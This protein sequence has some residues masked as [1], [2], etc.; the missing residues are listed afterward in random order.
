MT[1]L[2]CGKRKS[3][4]SP[5]NAAEDVLNAEFKDQRTGKIDLKPSA[6]DV[7]DVHSVIVQT[8]AEHYA[9]CGLDPRRL[10]AQAHVV[11]SAVYD[12]NITPDREGISF[13][14]IALAHRE[15]GFEDG[16]QLLQFIQRVLDDVSSLTR[17]TSKEEFERYVEDR[18]REGDTEWKA[19]AA[20]DDK[21]NRYLPP[22][23]RKSN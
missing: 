14:H 23:S 1:L 8:Y 9:Q 11:V 5:G 20:E 16:G 13:R 19:A 17:R 7:D 4:W 10:P 15:L 2:R 22:Q 3:S 21:W 6:Y 12:G 18:F